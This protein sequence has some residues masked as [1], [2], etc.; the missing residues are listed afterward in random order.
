MIIVRGTFGELWCALGVAT[1]S[2]L[3]VWA[4]KEPLAEEKKGRELTKIDRCGDAFVY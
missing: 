3:C 4:K 1:I 2:G